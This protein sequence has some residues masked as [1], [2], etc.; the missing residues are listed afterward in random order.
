MSAGN[1]DFTNFLCVN[2]LILNPSVG[3]MQ[4]ISSLFNFFRMVV[5]PALS[6]PLKKVNVVL[7]E[8]LYTY[9]KRRRISLSF[10]LFFLMIVS[11]PMMDVEC[12][13]NASH[14][15]LWSPA[16]TDYFW[17]TLHFSC[18]CSRILIS[19]RHGTKKQRKEGKERWRWLL[20]RFTD[21]Q[22]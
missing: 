20:V 22:E 8:H 7:I 14:A 18:S 16:G 19:T 13:L 12:K 15:G 1:L 10:C 17:L 9:R 6:R 2:V 21:A 11:S 4:L 3:L 5:F